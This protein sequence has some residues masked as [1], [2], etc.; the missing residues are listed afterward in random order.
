MF[1]SLAWGVGAL[2]VGYL[3]D[4]FG[5]D[6][7]F[8]FTYPFFIISFVLVIF[9]L[10][11]SEPRLVLSKSRDSTLDLSIADDGMDGSAHSTGSWHGLKDA[12]TVARYAL[13][14]SN[15]SSPGAAKNAS[16]ISSYSSGSYDPDIKEVVTEE[17]KFLVE[18]EYGTGNK[19]GIQHLALS[20]AHFQEVS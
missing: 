19:P 16:S 13:N 12:E 20:Q 5:M 18:I 1:G 3:I 9:C 6:S 4:E 15:E 8:F 17:E 7:I 2:V 11:S 14:M 10:P